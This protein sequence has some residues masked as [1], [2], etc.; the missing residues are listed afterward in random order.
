MQYS[1]SDELMKAGKHAATIARHKYQGLERGLVPDAKSETATVTFI[2]YKSKTYAV[3]AQHVIQT[4]DKLAKADGHLFE[5]YSCVQDPGVAILG[6]FLTPPAHYPEKEPDI[7]ICPVIEKLPAQIGKTAFEIRPEDDATWPITHALAVGFPTVEKHDI[8]DEF[9]ETKLALPCIHAVAEGLNSPGVSDQVQFHSELSKKPSIVS[10]SGMSGGPVFWSD[11]TNY[12]LIG[13][14]KEALDVTPK[15]GE[16]TFYIEPKVNF[17]CQRV[18]HVI[19]ERWLQYIDAN[20]Q[21]E[22]DKINNSIRHQSAAPSSD[23][24]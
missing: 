17:I 1:M 22:R 19:M 10:L 5:G 12:G 24:R 20:W 21:K 18:D 11:G 9:G 6:P 8:K 4:F 23:Q 13:F 14:V 16:E 15:E 7:A 2:K 3:T